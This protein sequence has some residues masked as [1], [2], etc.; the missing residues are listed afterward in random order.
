ML[1]GMAGLGIDTAP[2]AG[3]AG[4]ALDAWIEEA[5]EAAFQREFAEFR[6]QAQNTK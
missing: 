6:A 4:A 3:L 2:A 5:E 1:A